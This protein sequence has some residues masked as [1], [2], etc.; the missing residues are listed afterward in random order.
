M[1]KCLPAVGLSDVVFIGDFDED[2]KLSMRE[3]KH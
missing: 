2:T 1:K 3:S